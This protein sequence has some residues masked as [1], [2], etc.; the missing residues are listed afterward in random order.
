M[1]HTI[2]NF[3]QEL[4][5]MDKKEL[6]E[7]LDELQQTRMMEYTRAVRGESSL[8]IRLIKKQIAIIKTVM[9]EQK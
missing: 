8:D 2:N 6:Q 3:K 7:L 4:K 5:E 9:R 1:R